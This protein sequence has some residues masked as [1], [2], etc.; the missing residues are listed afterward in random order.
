MLRIWLALCLAALLGV[1]A[2]ANAEDCATSAAGGAASDLQA[3]LDTAKPDPYK[4]LKLAATNP[5]QSK[6]PASLSFPPEFIKGAQSAWDSSLPKGKSQEQGG[7]LVRNPDGSYEWKAGAPGQAG[8]WRA[9]YGDL[10]PKQELVALLHTHPYDA[11]EGG[12]T[13]VPFSGTDMALQVFQQ[14]PITVVQSGTGMFAAVASKEL[15]DRVN[16]LSTADRNALFYEIKAYYDKE[17][18]KAFSSGK[19][20]VDAVNTA[21]TST[22]KRY[23][24]IL[25]AGTAGAPL[26]RMVP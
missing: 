3:V 2:P 8:S 13:K 25:Y 11:T 5:P 14:E 1:G 24:F 21:V 15:L 17:L 4:D 6:A 16:K 23:Q 22:A 26:K 7:L 10:G 12:Y 20:F 9:N 18:D 19:G